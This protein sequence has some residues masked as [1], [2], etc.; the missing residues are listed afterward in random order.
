MYV[1]NNLKRFLL[2]YFAR[3]PKQTRKKILFEKPQ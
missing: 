2:I 3:E 1:Q